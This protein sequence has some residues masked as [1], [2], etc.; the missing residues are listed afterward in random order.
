MRKYSFLTCLLTFSLLASSAGTLSSP[1]RAAAQTRNPAR[2][3]KKMTDELLS[4]VRQARA[5]GGE[6]T[7]VILRAPEGETTERTRRAIEA[8]GAQVLG[9]FDEL[10]FVVADVP[11]DK[12]SEMASREEVSWVSPDQPVR[13]LATTAP[14]NTSHAEVTTGASKI[15]PRGNGELAKGGG[16]NRVGVAVLDSGISPPDAAE[17][18]GY[19]PATSGGLLGTGL[20]SQDTTKVYNRILKH[21]DFTGE[22]R[23]DDAYGHG[24]HTAGVAAGTGQASEDYAAKHPG[25]PTYGGVA[26]GANLVSVRVL[27]SQGIG[28]VS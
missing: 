25:S 17:F 26:T 18:A 9:Q 24:T 5:G 6:R 10:G 14:D 11:L 15:L 20:L 23:I 7:R 27:N 8:S 1:A 4:R 3:L 28:S 16:G 12:L 21:V 22:G 19:E 2:A 13:S